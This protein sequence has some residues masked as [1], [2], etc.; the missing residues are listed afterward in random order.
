MI[1]PGPSDA[2]PQDSTTGIPLALPDMKFAPLLVA[3][4]LAA[5]LAAQDPPMRIDVERVRPR[6]HVFSGFTNG[7]V[8][9][10]ETSD[11]L[12]LVD[13]QSGKRVGSLDSAI[14]NLSARPVRWVVNTHYHEDHTAGNAVFRARGARV[15][16]HRN[17][18]VQAAKDTTITD[19]NWHRTPLAAESM[20]TD[21]FDDRREITLGSD[22]V[23]VLHPRNAHT[24]G[25]AMVWIPGEN[26]L[27][28]GDI[29]E[30]DAPPFIDWWAG[31]TLD[32]MLAAIDDVLTWT[33]DS[34]AIVP[35]H[36]PVSSRAGLRRYREMMATVRDRVKAGLAAGVP[37][38][39]LAGSAVAGYEQML[40][41]ARRARQLV[42]QVAYGLRRR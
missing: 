12:L 16:A 40:G 30:V 2:P 35:G 6:I 1:F 21:A 27:H 28:I 8:L 17:L 41:G 23:V 36:G 34:T 10:L 38:D 24:D 11:G 39:S 19:R 14:T 5:P 29:L 3:S 20:P 9:V 13:A 15:L 42:P 22:R 33:N 18:A 4:L 25:D 31:G 7:N 32:G 26:V 37:V